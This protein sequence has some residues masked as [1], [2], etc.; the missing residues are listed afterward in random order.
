MK[1]TLWG[2]IITLRG[3]I[4]KC[5]DEKVT[6]RTEEEKRNLI[7]RLNKIEGQIR[8]VKAML[9]NDRYCLD[10]LIQLSA[11][12]SAVKSVM[13]VMIERHLKTCIKNE[14]I[15]DKNAAIGEIL[16]LFK[17]LK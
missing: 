7:S 14:M 15:T 3:E 11:V 17:R 10:I 8:G 2:Y 16:E 4:M 5:R 13:G 6:L 1:Y 12:R 9:D